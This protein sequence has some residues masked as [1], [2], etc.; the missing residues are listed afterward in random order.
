[1][2]PEPP[3][4]I[5]GMAGHVDHG[6]STL[7]AA[8]TGMAADR[9][10][11]EQHREMTIELGF[12]WLTLPSGAVASL[13][14]VPGHER[15]IK[16]MLAGVGS[17][18]AAL[19]VVAADEG[20]MPQTVEHLHILDLLEVQH[21]IVALTKA[22]LVDEEWLLLIEE[23]V[24]T[25]L[26]PTTLANAPIMP[27]SARQG[28]GLTPLVR[29]LDH[30]LLSLPPRTGSRGTPRLPVDR[31]FSVGGF[32]TVVT[33]TLLDGPLQVG[34][35]VVLLPAELRGRVRGL[36]SR[37]AATEV[38]LPGT[39]VAVNLAGIATD[40]IARGAV[41]T[42]PDVYT[43]TLL[44]DLE[45]RLVDDAPELAHNAA[46][47]VFV[48]A[49]EVGGH[50][51]LL[52][53]ATLGGGESGWAQLR[54]DAPILAVRGD[55]CVIRIPSPGQTIGGGRIVD[56][57]PSRHRRHR[58]EVLAALATL[59]QGTPAELLAQTLGD[60][61]PQPW[62][63]VAKASGLEAQSANAALAELVAQ[64][65]AL[66]LADAGQPTMVVI[67]ATG[68][69]K[70]VGAVVA[71]LGQYQASYPLRLGMARESLRQQVGLSN[72]RI[73]NTVLGRMAEE[74][75]IVLT[76]TLA[77]LP[78]W[79]PQFTPAQ[80]RQADALLAAFAANPFTPPARSEWEPLGNDLIALLIERGLLV[81]VSDEVL[82]GAEAYGK[83]VE[84]TQRTLGESGELSVVQLRDAFATSRKYAL[85]F[86]E[87]LDE[88]NMT[89][90]VGEVRIRN[91][92]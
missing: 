43:P 52:E 14:D 45:L 53:R 3:R 73:A 44:L 81:R 31:V 91:E 46:V 37:H 59:A 72:P 90:R 63:T 10:R 68:W 49:A 88:R 74:G 5:V 87:H 11:E 57:H 83:L 19:L 17:L 23:E 89:R 32:G 64:Q 61:G 20:V 67:A 35:E 36:Q 21:G 70:L 33:G 25:R 48:G 78:G 40:A 60:A 50:V 15:F 13:I 76:E 39:R 26:A 47:E 9:L 86:L 51:A 71:T 8:L 80:Q 24:R 41:L 55:R 1:M 30:L 42:L 79:E 77:H 92:R 28:V 82:F 38:A 56:A 54:L 66:V 12:T 16:N 2:N 58:P 27:V 7:V 4:F 84:W 65:A 85:A 62:K 29:T 6:K 22:D 69:R 75:S 34:Q 18:D